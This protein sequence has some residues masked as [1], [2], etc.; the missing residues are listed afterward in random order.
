MIVVCPECQA[1]VSDRAPVCPQCGFPIAGA[2]R[3]GGYENQSD[4]LPACGIVSIVLGSLG[5]LVCATGVG[6]LVAPIFFLPAII[7]GHLANSAYKGRRGKSSTLL[8]V[9]LTLEWV[10][11]LLGLIGL[12]GI[13]ITGDW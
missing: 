5:L 7:L 3:R 13:M 12:V 2:R 10:L 11:F 1:K 9:F 4:G 8:I 6:I